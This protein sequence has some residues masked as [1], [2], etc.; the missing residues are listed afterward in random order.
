MHHES[1]LK[2]S[3][4]V[5]IF[6]ATGCLLLLA[7]PLLLFVAYHLA[8]ARPITRLQAKFESIQV[9]QTRPEIIELLGSPETMCE[10]DRQFPLVSGHEIF[11]GDLD[12]QQQ[13]Q[14]VYRVETWYL[15]HIWVVAFD[16]AGRVSVAY[17]LE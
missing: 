11:C 4:S 2:L 6:V 16:S 5:D 3:S 8:I 15:P 12:A 9:G 7:S 14:Y 13:V 1:K 17:R 10:A